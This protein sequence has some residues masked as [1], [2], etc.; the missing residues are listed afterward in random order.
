VSQRKLLPG[1]NFIRM[2]ILFFQNQFA[3]GLSRSGVLMVSALVLGHGLRAQMNIAALN[4]A[5]TINFDGTVGG[6][7]SGVWAG[8]GFQP[9]PTT[10]RLDSD[11]WAVTGW[12]NGNLAFGG[13]Q[14]TAS[15]DYRRGIATG[16]VAVG[17][18]YAFDDGA[19][20]VLNGRAL[21][22][23]PGSSDWAPGTITLRVQNN[24]GSTITAFDIAYNVYYR[25]DQAR[26]SE[27]NLFT[28]SD[29]V[30][31]TQISSQDVVSPAGSAGTAWVANAR[32]VTV[33]GLFVPNGQFFYVRWRGADV[34][35]TG[36]ARDEFALDDISITGR[37]YTVV[38]FAAATSTVSENVGS[39]TVTASITNP[40]PVNATTVDV[41][42]TSGD[43][44]R[45]NNYTTQTLTFPGG[46][47]ANQ[48]VTITAT[49][50]GACDGDVAQVFTLQNIAG[51]ATP[52]IGSPSTHTMT[53]DDDET[54]AQTF[55]Q[56]FDGGVGDNWA[57]T[58]GGGNQS[59][60]TGAT[61]TPANQRV[62][63][64]AQSW[65]VNNG[66]VTLDLGTVSL[67]DWSGITLSARVSSTSTLATGGSDGADSVAFYVNLNGTGFPADPDVRIAGN[68]NA[69]W[70]YATGTGVAST[71]AGIPVNFAPATGGNRTTDGFSTVNITIPNGTTSIALR[72]IATNNDP[73]EIWNLDNVQ[74]IGTLCSPVYYSRANG[75]EVTATWSTSRTG[76]PA[77]GAVTFNKN[78]SMVVQNTHAVTTTNN[79]GIALRNLN[80]ETGGTLTLT[81]VCNVEING[82]T[83]DVDGVMNSSNDNFDLVSTALT[84]ISGSA[85]TIDVND[86]T[87]DGFGAIVTV[88]TLKIRGTLQL[89]N[90]NF[91]ANAKEVQLI[92]TASGT[93]RLGP[94]AATASY[95]DRLRI[96]RYIPAGVTDWR[97]LC[98]PVAGRTVSD[99]TDDFYTAGFPGSFYPNFFVNNA[100]WPSVRQY[101]ET[102]VGALSTDGLIGVSSVSEPL[103]VGKG[104]AA[105]SGTTLNTTSA[106]TIDV[107]GLPTVA[108]TPFSIPLTFTNTGNPTVDGLNLVGNPLPSPI[109]FSDLTLTN[110][111]NSY[112]IYD[113]GS[114]TNSAWDESTQIGT[115]GAN[116]NIQSSQGFW[117]KANAAS[118]SAILDESAKVLEPINGGI[119]SDEQDDRLLV[120]LRLAGA[121]TTYTDEAVVHFIA[122]APGF[123]APDMVK[124]A[125]SN[126]NA[127]HISTKATTGEDLV[128]NAY[129]DPAQAMDIPVKV[130]VPASG[131]YTISFAQVAALRG[132]ACVTL[133]DL[134][135]GTVTDVDPD[136]SYT[137]DI[138]A[139]A[140]IEPARFVLHVGAAV[141]LTATDASC[142]G[143]S[144]GSLVVAG[145]GA[146]SFTYSIT[147]PQG[148]VQQFTA[149]GAV[150]FDELQ[151]GIYTVAVD[152]AMGCG[153]LSTQV[154]INAPG[155]MEATGTAT[156]ATCGTA[157]D[158]TAAVEVMGGTAPYVVSW[159]NGGTG[160]AI[161]G[162]E[163]G[164][165]S[166][167][168]VDANGCSY[169][170]SPV[171][172]PAGEGPVAS[173]DVSANEVLVGE[174]VFF[175]NMGTYHL[176]YTWDMG[177]GVVTDEAEPM[178][179]FNAPGVYTVNLTTIDGDCSASYAAQVLVSTSTGLAAPSIGGLSAWLD[180]GFIAVRWDVPGIDVLQLDL[181]DATGRSVMARQATGASGRLML[182]RLDL[183]AGV[184]VLR[185]T[186]GREQRTFK[187]ALDR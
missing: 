187:L 9:V 61:D 25:D 74:V 171:Q 122:G 65:Q 44:A 177:D 64:S 145:P 130:R 134:L 161:S 172:V 20:G 129:G 101:D 87:L 131:P 45:I 28:S 75:S 143:L 22:F 121:D 125:F 117:L 53:L 83:L 52:S 114:G 1:L 111:D 17:G 127:P 183:P 6:V 106:F 84:T 182:P 63:S 159:S 149:E 50:N 180:G 107:R 59:A 103:T 26:S 173:F 169:S 69:R 24:T 13:T 68:S 78:A 102:N 56:Y 31:Y 105:W 136:A 76:S 88:N 92:S 94:V 12:S 36:T 72:V 160:V 54:A 135:T 176:A 38:R 155:P 167:T 90:G 144:D 8:G 157:T 96:E 153:Q 142:A 174:E 116:G 126:D 46:S 27:F 67:L 60:A 148:Q 179:V 23:Q 62:L 170:I 156:A 16:P 79:A 81:G 112:Y 123:G 18:M 120:R 104:F 184:Y 132:R 137:F 49:D 2:N 85:G 11:A 3:L 66:T 34:G 10:G 139:A 80:V 33:S 115:G 98:S 141:S 77:P 89:D 86:M 39:T 133:E 151:S 30:T 41:A 21:G 140:P 138:D 95:S 58:A 178:H 164:A 48:S 146:G 70:G 4:T 162:L 40:D 55:A 118:P 82:P 19:G 113:P 91:N 37:A 15:T 42:L 97:L 73:N 181:L 99:W 175:F 29:N 71:T 147:D 186:A 152:G 108:S 165:Y 47:L 43:A 185:A 150:V 109:D 168:V 166:A 128:I 163:P 154:A 119:F 5:Y 110:V 93:A 32:A 14:I 100:L 124:L 158:G 57:I 51:G 7:G 35:G